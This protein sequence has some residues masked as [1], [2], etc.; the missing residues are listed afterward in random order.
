MREIKIHGIYKHF[1]G[2]YYLVEEIAKDCETLEDVVIYRKLYE[3]GSC[4]VRPLKDFM[5]KVDHIKYPKVKQKYRFE[6][7]EIES[8]ASKFKGE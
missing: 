6:L 5:G 4:W 2:D 3:D 1:K 8:V 7:M